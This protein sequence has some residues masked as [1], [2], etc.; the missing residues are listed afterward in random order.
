MPPIPAM[1]QGWTVL[2]LVLNC[3]NLSCKP[4][5][6]LLFFAQNAADVDACELTILFIPRLLC[7]T[8]EHL[9]HEELVV[10]PTMLA[11]PTNH[12]STMMPGNGTAASAQ[13]VQGFV[14]QEGDWVVV[15]FAA[16]DAV[17]S[18][19]YEVAEVVLLLSAK[20]CSTYPYRSL[21]VIWR[22]RDRTDCHRWTPCA[23]GDQMDCVLSPWDVQ[24]VWP[25]QKILQVS[26]Q[27]LSIFI[28]W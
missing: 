24:Q 28:R 26:Q 9:L 5:E 25:Y 8:P 18:V 15:P 3:S 4:P 16:D 20:E 1:M 23:L 13:E 7:D 17:S 22:Q 12:S 19:N 6:T 27:I 11:C 21:F 2:P 14:V 10:S